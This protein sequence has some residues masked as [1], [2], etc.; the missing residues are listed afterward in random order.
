MDDNGS[1]EIGYGKPPRKNQFTKGHSGNPKGRP[2]GSKNLSTVV[3]RESRQPVRVNGP[4]GPRTVTKLVAAAMQMNNKAA[5]GDLR[6]I[7]E[8]FEIVAR[9]EMQL[10]ASS[11]REPFQEADRRVLENVCRRFEELSKSQATQVKTDPGEE[12]K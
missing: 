1:D 12:S 4:R 11:T 3:L 8:L 9:S 7:C 10:G 5:Q 6:A 2:R